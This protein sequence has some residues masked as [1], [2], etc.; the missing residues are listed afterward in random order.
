MAGVTLDPYLERVGHAGPVRADEG[1]LHTLHVAHAGAVPFENLDIHLGRPIRTDLDNVFAKLVGD[2]RGGYCFEQNT[3]FRA[4]LD[5][6][7]FAT[8]RRLARVRMGGPHGGRTHLLT[9]VHI[10]A[11]TWVADL[12]F[13]GNNLVEPLLLEAGREQVSGGDRFRL[14]PSAFQPGWELEVLRPEG[15]FPLYWFGEEAVADID[16]AIANHF[17][18]THPES[19]FTLNRILAR[20]TRTARHTLLNGEYKCRFGTA[21]LEERRVRGEAEFRA[22]LADR[23]NLALPDG[24]ELRSHPEI[25]EP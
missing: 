25:T 10:G 22:L 16:L 13:G 2:R 15:W 11:H 5:L 8:E 17:T 4:M 21:V 1:T 24:A 9:L 19:R 7:G 3:L 12:G 20:A 23:F 6:A 14:L 18:S